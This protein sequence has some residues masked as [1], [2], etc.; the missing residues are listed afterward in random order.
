MLTGKVKMVTFFK[1]NHVAYNSNFMFKIY[2]VFIGN[3]KCLKLPHL[4]LDYLVRFFK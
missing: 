2:R 1:M 4:S 3:S